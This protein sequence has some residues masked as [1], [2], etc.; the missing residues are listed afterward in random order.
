MTWG[1]RFRL[2]VGLIAVLVVAALG[3]YHLNE[4]RGVAESS[5]AQIAADSYTVGA[6]YA[7]LVVDQLVEVGQVV[8]E[9]DALFVIESATLQHDI[10]VGLV[11][12]G[13]IGEDL[14]EQGRFVVRATG[15]GTVTELD[16]A[17]GTFVQASS[18]VATVQK[19]ASLYVQAEYE[20][21]TQE[22]ARLADDARVTI[23]LPDERE[24][25][26]RVDGLS[27]TTAGGRAQVVVR[28]T[29]PALTDDAHD[30]PLVAAGTPVTARLHLRNDGVVTRVSAAVERFVREV[31]S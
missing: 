10:A 31:A 26:G 8:A 21:G 24:L 22:Y 1:N 30:D 3:T 5:S 27:V 25:T 13:A 14:D 7:G 4:T 16:A 20:L 17:A 2:A 19:A 29:S 9:N 6:A 23:V 12:S 18:E 15:P 11:P 28:V